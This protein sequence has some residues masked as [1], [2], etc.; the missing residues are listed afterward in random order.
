MSSATKTIISQACSQANPTALPEILTMD[1]TA[2]SGHTK[3]DSKW[4]EEKPC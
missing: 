2:L 3:K 1:P 4:Y